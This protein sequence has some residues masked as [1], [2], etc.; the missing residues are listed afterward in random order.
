MDLQSAIH[1]Q[2][3]SPMPISRNTHLKNGDQKWIYNSAIHGQYDSPM[4]I[5]RNTHLKN[6]DQKWIYN[7][8]ILVQSPRL[9]REM[10]P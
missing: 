9:F 10:S 3:D 4:P 6:G 8:A 7:S 1:G 5:S 2:H